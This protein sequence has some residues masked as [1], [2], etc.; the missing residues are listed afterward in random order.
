MIGKESPL[1]TVCTLSYN[2]GRYVLDGLD[3]VRAQ[4]HTNIQHLI[5]D[6][7]SI[8]NSVALIEDW[9][10]RHRYK[11][12]FIKRSVN[13]GVCKG[14]NKFLQ[15]AEGK[16]VAF[17]SDDL[18]LPTHLFGAISILEEQ[19]KEVGAIYSDCYQS[20][21][22]GNLAP[23]LLIAHNHRFSEMPQGYIGERLWEGNF[24]PA[25][26][27]VVRRECFNKVGGFDE[28]LVYEDWDMWLRLSQF[29][30]FIY[31]PI[32]R[33]IYRIIPTSM[34]QSRGAAI[35]ASTDRI[36]VK[37][38][39]SGRLPSHMRTHALEK[40]RNGAVSSYFLQS[41]DAAFFLRNAVR[42]SRRNSYFVMYI[43]CILGIPP[44]IYKRIGI[45]WSRVRALL[46]RSPRAHG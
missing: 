18:W 13:I 7:C 32:P 19:S 11:C 26:S 15:L 29:Y 6:D 5:A 27:V 12:T 1:V 4:T 9:I 22:Q 20:D 23:E 17:V 45:V 43:F 10:K 3:S 41:K 46:V 40:L 21:A 39:I 8:D 35:S 36:L 30:Q 42:F 34:M 37:G 16:Y 28:N 44:S 25:L 14:L 2:N 31:S 24:I 33:A 38:L